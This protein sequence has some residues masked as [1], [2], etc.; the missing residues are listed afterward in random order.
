MHVV[1]DGKIYININISKHQRMNTIKIS[2]HAFVA[3]P[4]TILLVN[5]LQNSIKIEFGIRPVTFL[6][7][8]HPIQDQRSL[9]GTQT[10]CML[11][12][13]VNNQKDVWDKEEIGSSAGMG[14]FY[15]YITRKLVI[16]GLL[17][18]I[19]WDINSRKNKPRVSCSMHGRQQTSFGLV[20]NGGRRRRYYIG[21][22]SRTSRIYVDVDLFLFISPTVNF[23]SLP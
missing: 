11:Q 1:V 21:Y 7:L 12:A 2:L 23:L 3:Y 19:V 14:K 16:V 13:F 9:Q 18:N 4:G 5:Y 10:S 8:T 20:S 22:L 6:I 15:L 17:S